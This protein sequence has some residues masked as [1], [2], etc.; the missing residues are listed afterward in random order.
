M[1]LKHQVNTRL[2][3]EDNAAFDALVDVLGSDRASL[4][5]EAI[6]LLVYGR[7]HFG[8]RWPLIEAARAIARQRVVPDASDDST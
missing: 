8:D 7:E 5:R 6:R 4:T 3:D 1:A 2:D